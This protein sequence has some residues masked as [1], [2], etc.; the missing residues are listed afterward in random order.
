MWRMRRN[1]TETFLIFLTNFFHYGIDELLTNLAQ[2]ISFLVLLG[3]YQKRR[4]QKNCIH[5]GKGG[6]LA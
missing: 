6:G 4:R 2:L 5:V 1:G 3:S